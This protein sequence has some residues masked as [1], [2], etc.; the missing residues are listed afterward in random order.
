M[1]LDFLTFFSV[2]I[3]FLVAMS[4]PA[5]AVSPKRNQFSGA[6]TSATIKKCVDTLY[7][8]YDLCRARSGI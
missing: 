2:A 6:C 8:C 5:Q 3:F 1:K 4:G 7:Q